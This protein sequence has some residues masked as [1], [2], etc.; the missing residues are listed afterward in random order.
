MS[1]WEPD[2]TRCTLQ[3]LARSA[4][5]EIIPV[6]GVEEKLAGV[7]TGSTVTITC[8]APISVRP[9]SPSRG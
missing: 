6:R 8:S 5:I 3:R 4:K 1:T 9:S 2:R 7:P